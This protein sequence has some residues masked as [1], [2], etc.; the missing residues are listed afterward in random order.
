MIFPVVVNGNGACV[1]FTGDLHDHFAFIGYGGVLSL[2]NMTFSNFN[3]VYHNYGTL[4]LLDCIFTDNIDGGIIKG[5]GCSNYLV[6]CIF[7]GNTDI[8]D[9]RD[10][11]IRFDDCDFA[12]R[13]IVA[14]VYNSVVE[15]SNDIK[16]HLILSEGSVF[17]NTGL[18]VVNG[19][20][21][22][23]GASLTFDILNNDY[24]ANLSRDILLY[25]PSRLVLN[26]SCD[27]DCDLSK[28]NYADNLIIL[29]NG[30][31]V[32]FDFGQT[33]DINSP[34]TFVNLT[35]SNYNHRIF[36]IANSCIFAS[37]NF[38]SNTGDYLFL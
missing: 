37:C 19:T 23:R 25:E 10:A 7:K 31:R 38:T 26:I 13:D 17:Y 9:I 1:K 35:F 18:T 33:I 36:N 34:V 27:C 12:G 6:N 16:N 28:L 15:S 30:H 29:G 4:N 20:I 14:R 32:N 22:N 11:F 2:N 24:L 21:I 8:V 5:A 3:G